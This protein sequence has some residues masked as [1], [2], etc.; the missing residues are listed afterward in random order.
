MS[1]KT[2]L[3]LI[4]FLLI[5]GLLFS[6]SDDE[7]SDPDDDPLLLSVCTE[8]TNCDSTGADDPATDSGSSA[9]SESDFAKKFPTAFALQLCWTT[10]ERQTL[11]AT[12]A[13]PAA[14]DLLVELRNQQGALLMTLAD[15]D[16]PAGYVPLCV[17]TEFL[18]AGVYAVSM[19]ATDFQV[20]RQ[21]RV[22]GE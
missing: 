19:Q 14:S 13:L 20:I 10:A 17:D 8:S 5:A 6:C 22:T 18:T 1:T 4:L 15:D 16:L 11:V 12:A 7:G 3:P 2:F 9:L 21:F